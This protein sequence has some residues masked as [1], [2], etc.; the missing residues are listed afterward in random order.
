MSF[1]YK[2]LPHPNLTYPLKMEETNTETVQAIEEAFPS[3]SKENNDAALSWSRT[4]KSKRSFCDRCK[5]PNPKA[6]ICESLPSKSIRLS[7]LR[8]LI[9]QHPHERKRKNRSVPLLQLSLSP[10]SIIVAVGRRLG[11]KLSPSLTDIIHEERH[12]PLLLL[13][14]SSDA[15]P[16]EEALEIIKKERKDSDGKATIVNVLVLDGTWKYARE[17]DAANVKQN[18][19]PDNMIRVE[20]K[21]KLSTQFRPF[22]FDIRNPPSEDHLS[23][24][25]SIAWA[26]SQIEEDKSLYDKL[27]KPLDCMV[28]KWKSFADNNKMKTKDESNSDG[29]GMGETKPTTTLQENLKKRPKIDNEIID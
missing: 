17:M 18:H 25:E 7:K 28:E 8:I 22:R 15:I 20:I 1:L 2:Y 14:P 3:Q 4:K 9:L 10:E 21:P 19:Y 26:A 24:A 13:Y 27:V 6:C 11:D 29:D 12:L 23:T 16:L 5:R